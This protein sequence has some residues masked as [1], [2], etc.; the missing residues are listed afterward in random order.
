[1]PQ[2]PCLSPRRDRAKLV[3]LAEKLTSRADSLA[4][5]RP[6]AEMKHGGSWFPASHDPTTISLGP[7]ASTADHSG[8]RARSPLL[9]L[10]SY[11]AS[12]A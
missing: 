10:W 2:D 8:Q 12:G 5:R 7:V 1:M 11:L 4:E 6:P 3:G 9:S